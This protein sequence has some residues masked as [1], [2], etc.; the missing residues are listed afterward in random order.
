MLDRMLVNLAVYYEKPMTEAQVKVYSDLLIDENILEIGT[1]I[2]KHI[3]ASRFFPKVSEI[4]DLMPSHNQPKI[5]ADTVA[6]GQA[7]QILRLIRQNGSNKEPKYEDTITHKLMTTRWNWRS[8]CETLKESESQWF[9]KEFVSAYCAH[10]ELGANDDANL[11][12]EQ[13]QSGLDAMRIASGL[14]KRIE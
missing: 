10:S 3:R 13:S 6:Q 2:K 11:Q 4:L 9:V 7:H 1:A 8:L 5:S 12:I 14:F